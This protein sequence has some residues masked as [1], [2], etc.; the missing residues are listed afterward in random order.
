MRVF[1]LLAWLVSGIGAAPAQQPKAL[2]SLELPGRTL[3]FRIAAETIP[4]RDGNGRIDAEAGIVAF[5]REG[6]DAARPVTFVIGG[7]PGT[8]S[9]YLN[10]GAL[11]PWRIPFAVSGAR[12]AFAQCRYLARFH[13]SCLRRSARHRARTTG[14]QRC[15]S[16]GARMVG[17]W[18]R[19]VACR[20]DRGVA[21]QARSRGICRSR[22]WRRAMAACARRASPKACIAV[23]GFRFGR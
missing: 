19:R 1:L 21:A 12:H 22:W 9:A 11:G 10:L 15:E 3:A 4:V 23:T 18:R 13:R 5:L 20:C 7:G 2:N 16:Q 17:R 6:H 8:A 14:G